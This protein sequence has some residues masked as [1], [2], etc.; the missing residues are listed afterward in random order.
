MKE[1]RSPSFKLRCH[2]GGGGCYLD[3]VQKHVVTLIAGGSKEHSN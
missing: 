3:I 2:R 1:F